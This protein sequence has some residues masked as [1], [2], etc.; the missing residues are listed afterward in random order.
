MSDRATYS[1]TALVGTTK[2]GTL[3]CDP[4]GYYDVVLGGLDIFNSANAFY[5]LAPAKHLFEGSSDMM[6]RVSNGALRG[7]YGHPKMDSNMSKRDFLM[8][9]L[10][11]E[12]SCVSHHIREVTLES[13]MRDK[14][15]RSVTAIM[16]RIKPM[17]PHAQALGDSL[18]NPKENVCFSIR[19]LTD[20]V[21]G[22]GGSRTKI[23]KEIVTWDYVNEPGI[24]IANK[25][26]YP[27]LEDISSHG[28]DKSHLI[29]AQKHA[30]T[31]VGMG[32]ESDSGL[33]I[34]S[35]IQSFGWQLPIDH[36]KIA[37][38]LPPSVRW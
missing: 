18:D 26:S 17:G 29:A 11:I 34:A 21:I 35:A 19:S 37:R 1:C 32:M 30:M 10:R 36:A 16:G 20:D 8:R 14:M 7:E 15:G 24:A 4:D 2:T 12:E 22:Q 28:F 9:V 13:G 38:Q 23:L 25:Y 31:G 5:P 3:R 27:A 33:I 6:R